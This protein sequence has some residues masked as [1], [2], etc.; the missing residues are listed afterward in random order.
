MDLA[1]RLNLVALEDRLVV[2]DWDA[3]LPEDGQPLLPG[4]DFQARL[5]PGGA[6]GLNNGWTLSLANREYDPDRDHEALHSLPP[7]EAWLDA[8]AAVLPLVVRAKQAGE[9]WQPLGLEG[10]SQKLSDFFTNEKI[11]RHLRSRWP[12]VCTQWGTAWVAGLRPAEPFKVSSTTR[13]ILH[14]K[15]VKAKSD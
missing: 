11:P 14:L 6:V 5:M 2:K 7:N 1:A 3:A 4:A 12:L 10:H 9:H 8:E 15:L 13:Q